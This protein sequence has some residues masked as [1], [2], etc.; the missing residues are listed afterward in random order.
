MYPSCPP[1]LKIT[2]RALIGYENSLL[3]SI[4]SALSRDGVLTGLDSL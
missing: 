1:A 2:Q 4:L 3:Y